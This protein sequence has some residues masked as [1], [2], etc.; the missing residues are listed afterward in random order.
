MV[1]I[2]GGIGSGKS[3][4]TQ[5]FERKGVT[6][7]DADLAA[8]VVVEPGRPALA[9]IANHFGKNILQADGALDRAALRQRVFADD[10]ERKWL[11][12]LTHPLIGQEIVDQLQAAQS[13]Y[14]ILA[15]PLLLETSQRDLTDLVV[16][17]DV[18]EE[19][20]IARTMSRDNNDEAQVRRIIAA[21]MDRQDRLARADIVIDNSKSLEDLDLTVDELHKEFLAKAELGSNRS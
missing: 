3:A 20:Q 10:S 14:A 2:T 1:G 16:V 13:P 6:V 4:V 9:A 8:R 7:V 21:Q 17:V 18:P 5:R 11:E 15:S 12:Q 19:V